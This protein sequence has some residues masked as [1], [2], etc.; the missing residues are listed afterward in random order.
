VVEA[1]RRSLEQEQ[2]HDVYIDGAIYVLQDPDFARAR[3]LQRIVETL[4][5]ERWLRQLLRPLSRER[6]VCVRIGAENPLPAAAGCGVVAMTYVGAGGLR[7]VIA[8]LGPKRMPYWRAVSA[9]SCVA[10]ELT[11]HLGRE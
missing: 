7:G 11:Q 5:Q 8:A 2:Q 6:D 3:E 4:Y 9:V 1:I 10:G